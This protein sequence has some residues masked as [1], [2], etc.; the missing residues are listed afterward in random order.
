MIFQLGINAPL[1]DSASQLFAVVKNAKMMALGSGLT[2][3]HAVGRDSH[4]YP[5][6]SSSWF[7]TDFGL[8]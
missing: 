2:R 8:R 1:C 4:G 5:C 7:D 3:S 6:E